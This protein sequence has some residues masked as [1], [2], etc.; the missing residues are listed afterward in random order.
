MKDF[1][2]WQLMLA[3]TP[4]GTLFWCLVGLLCGLAAAEFFPPSALY[5]AD[6]E[7][8][9][10]NPDKLNYPLKNRFIRWQVV[11]ACQQC[12]ECSGSLD[13]GCECNSCG[14]DAMH[15]LQR[16]PIQNGAIAELS[17]RVR[18]L[19]LVQPSDA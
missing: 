12:P 9:M 3:T 16:K 8:G 10:I 17:D 1:I 15:L 18:H 7:T 4:Q 5:R 19:R 13:T 2:E 11:N 6:S 14:Y